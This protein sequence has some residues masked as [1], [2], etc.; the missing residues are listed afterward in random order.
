MGEINLLFFF[1]PFKHR[2]V[3]NPA[4]GS[5]RLI[6]QLQLL[7]QVQAYFTEKGIGFIAITGAKEQGIAIFSFHAGNQIGLFILAQEF[8]NWPFQ[9]TFPQRGMLAP[10]C[11]PDEWIRSCDWMGLQRNL[12]VVGIFARLHY[13][14]HK[15]GYLD[16]IPRFYGYLLDVTRRYPEFRDA[17]RLLEKAECAP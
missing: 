16:M 15:P 6:N 9:L 4:E 8:D 3:H 5:K 10:A 12:K 2:E 14:D 11:D 1:I 7:S 17:Y 13:R